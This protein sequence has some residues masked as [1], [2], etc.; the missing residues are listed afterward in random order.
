MNLNS[1]KYNLKLMYIESMKL[2]RKHNLKLIPVKLKSY[3]TQKYL[4]VLFIAEV[5]VKL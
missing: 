3:I 5:Y 1:I 4:V 2:V